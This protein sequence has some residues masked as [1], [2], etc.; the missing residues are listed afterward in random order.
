MDEM[1]PLDGGAGCA[2]CGC[3]KILEEAKCQPQVLSVTPV[4][5]NTEST[6][7][8]IKT[9]NHIVNEKH[10]LKERRVPVPYEVEVI[11]RVPVKKIVQVPIH[12]P[13]QVPVQ[14]P[15]YVKEYVPQYVRKVIPI[16]KKVY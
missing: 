5:E 3:E 16:E 9:Y 13:V 6:V 8:G 15:V 12:V 14:K 2:E 10:I 4:C 11:E 1:I 7:V